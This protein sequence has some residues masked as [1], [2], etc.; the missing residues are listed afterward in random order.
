MVTYNHEKYIRQSIESVLKQKTEFPFQLIIGE[1]CSKDNTR[2]IVI[3][4][5]NRYPDIIK[6]ILNKRNLGLVTNVSNVSSSCKGKYILF[7]DGDD[8]WH[9]IYKMQT[10]VEYMESHPEVGIVHGDVNHLIESTNELIECYNKKYNIPIPEGSI[11]T[12]LLLSNHYFLKTMSSCI[13]KE[14]L[15]KYYDFN[16]PVQKQWT[17]YDLPIWLELAKHSKINYINESFGT[18]RISDNSVSNQIDP[19]QRYKF[20]K[21]VFD[22]KLY[23]ANKYGSNMGIKNRILSRAYS[24][25]LYDSFQIGD[26]TLAK[27][28][29]LEMK[30]KKIKI[31]FKDSVI[32]CLTK[33]LSLNFL[34]NKVILYFFK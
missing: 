6:A 8:Y 34:T 32:I 4:Y 16:L 24:V 1:D 13:R 20:H 9:N 28:L 31:S 12:E 25:F 29:M 22:V 2:N 15:D 3:E 21:S 30:K 11:F 14:L 17:L 26:Y 10:Q 7:C 33:L 27:E 5:A 18:Y 19:V 23:Y